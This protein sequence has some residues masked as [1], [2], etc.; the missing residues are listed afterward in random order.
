MTR[1]ARNLTFAGLI[2]GA[3]VMALPAS[4]NSI[5]NEGYFGG[6][7][8]RIAPSSAYRDWRYAR[9]VGPLYG[10]RFY[11]PRYAYAPYTYGYGPAYY[12]PGYY[13]PSVSVGV[14]IGY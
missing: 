5:H 1:T 2:A 12:G 4:A 10:P 13:G 7:Y 6:T 14:G 11:G 3:S 8:T 9:R